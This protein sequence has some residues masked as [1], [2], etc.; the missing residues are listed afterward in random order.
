M[1]TTDKCCTIVPYF[2]I[3]PGKLDAAR[4]MC[5]EFVEMTKNEVKCLFYGFSFSGDQVHCREG[6]TDAD[7]ALAHLQN[8]G[9]KLQEFLKIADLT[10]LELHGPAEQLE[11]LRGPLA[12][13]KPQLFVLEFGFR[14]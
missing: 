11:K 9:P 6:Y 4:A 8:V 7:G 10:R 3:H 2:Q 12:D 13:F 14:R 5:D 1:A